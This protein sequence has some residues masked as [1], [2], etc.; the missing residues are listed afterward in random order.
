MFADFTLDLERGVL[1]QSGNVVPLRPKTFSVLQYLVE[2]AGQL[3]SKEELMKAIWPDVLVTDD[4]IA[5]CVVELR[6]ALGDSER[7]MI[8][9][10]PRRGLIFDVP[11]RQSAM[12]DPVSG[13]SVSSRARAIL[14]RPG[15]L[16]SVLSALCLVML[17]AWTGVN[18]PAQTFNTPPPNSIAVLPF[19]DM[20]PTGDQA[21]FADGISEEIL[22]HLAQSQAMTVISRTSSFAFRNSKDYV[23]SIA[24]KLGVAYLLE[25]SLRA[26]GN[27]LRVTAQLIEAENGQQLWSGTYDGQLGEIFEFQEQIARG[28]TGSLDVNLSQ[29][30]V[31]SGV[32][33][34]A[35]QLFLEGRY[36]YQRRADNDLLRARDRY[37][38]ALSI[39][40]DFAQAWTGLAATLAILLQKSDDAN[41]S[42]KSPEW[43]YLLKELKHASEGALRFGDGDPEAHLRAGTYYLLVNDWEEAYQQFRIAHSIS[44]G[45]WLVRARMAGILSGVGKLDAAIS[46][47]EKDVQRDPLNVSLRYNLVTLLVW[48]RR[49]EDAN[50]EL[51]RVLDLFPALAKESADLGLLMGT[52][53]ILLG[54]MNA[55]KRTLDLQLESEQ[56]LQ[57]LALRSI[58]LGN[59]EQFETELSQL[60]QL[61]SDDWDALRIAE[62]YAFHGEKERALH[63]LHKIDF[64]STCQTGS[65]AEKVYYSPFLG[66]LGD[67]PT[68]KRIQSRILEGNQQCLHG[69]EIEPV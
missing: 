7:I 50:A 14:S 8:R 18:G 23:R 66:N 37:E 52:V 41:S 11:I 19:V 34:R 31:A 55:A 68:W 49:L 46:I 3:V 65:L 35:Y 20:S 43:V 2:H 4:S 59:N 33:P 1:F 17:L 47:Y 21:Y 48:S 45:N 29:A 40:P 62:V 9:T 22:N 69:F 28:V 54:D 57:L 39:S 10:V 58:A 51:N 36:L 26:D 63:W 42:F 13:K 38:E 60:I 44:P 27:D 30:V 32:D 64:R 12:S 25:G 15:G 61:A 5:Q 56:K 16:V 53:N 67:F 6:R 24:R